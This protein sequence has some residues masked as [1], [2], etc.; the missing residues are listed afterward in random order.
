MET[1]KLLTE[2]QDF[3]TL[4][5][6]TESAEDGS[7]VYRIKGPFLQAEVKNRNGRIYSKTLLEREIKNFVKEKVDTKRAMG[8]LD[9]PA[10]PQIN[11]DR[12]SHLIESLDM[13]GNDGMGTAKL[14][15]T[16]MGRIAQTLVKDGILLG[17]STRGVGSLKGDKVNED[18]KMIT[19][20]LVADPSAPN[21]F[22]E[23]ILEGKNYIIGDDGNIVEVAI[24]ELQRKVDNKGLGKITAQFMN[25]FITDLK[26]RL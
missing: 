20:D 25:D 17:V 13:E 10:T 7:K 2:F 23:G 3:S 24:A 9:H 16:P 21:A 26:N 5:V 6:L 8:E 11:L 14:L 22:V 12:V 1:L 4:E 18:Y 15:D 19:I